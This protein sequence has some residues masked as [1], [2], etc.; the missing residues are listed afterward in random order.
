MIICLFVYIFDLFLLLIFSLVHYTVIMKPLNTS[1]K[2]SQAQFRV[3]S[4]NTV[5][6]LGGV[7]CNGCSL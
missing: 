4:S 7:G 5:L 2:I 6:A 3:I 1:I